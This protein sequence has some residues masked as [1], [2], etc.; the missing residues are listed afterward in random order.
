MQVA[1]E[2]LVVQDVIE[3]GLRTG[4]SCWLVAFP[5]GALAAG[6]RWLSNQRPSILFGLTPTTFTLSL[7]GATS[8]MA[9]CSAPGSDSAGQRRKKVGDVRLR[10]NAAAVLPAA[11]RCLWTPRLTPSPIRSP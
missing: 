5:V 11:G 9:R 6:A 2:C 7:G 10:T 1:A 3:C 4:S 8:S